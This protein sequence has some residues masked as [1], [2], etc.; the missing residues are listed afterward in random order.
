MTAYNVHTFRIL[1][2]VYHTGYMQV[3]FWSNRRVMHISLYLFLDKIPKK[4]IRLEAQAHLVRTFFG[5]HAH[6]VQT[7]FGCM[8]TFF[9]H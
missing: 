5:V 9:R 6:H 1:L 2:S 4:S 8:H 3:V 7:I